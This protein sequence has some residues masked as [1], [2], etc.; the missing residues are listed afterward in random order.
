MEFLNLSLFSSE[1]DSLVNDLQEYKSKISPLSKNQRFYKFIFDE[2]FRKFFGM[3]FIQ[4]MRQYINVI[5]PYL[6]LKFI[7]ELLKT[8][9]AGVNNDFFTHNPFK[10]LKGQLFYAELIKKTYPLLYTLKTGKGYS[11]KDLLSFHGNV[12]IATSFTMKRLNKRIGAQNLNN[13]GILSG[14]GTYDKVAIM[15]KFSSEYYDKNFFI[16]VL[17]SKN[18]KKDELVRNKLIET[19]STNL[20]LKNII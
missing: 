17:N 18:W 1:M 5:N 14:I 10:R 13:L 6:D 16:D 12:K 7:K 8:D 2:T 11:P 19:L 20:N 9:L 15:E 4:P 3:Q